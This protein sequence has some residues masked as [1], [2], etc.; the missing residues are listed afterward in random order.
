MPLTNIV[1]LLLHLYHFLMTLIFLADQGGS[2]KISDY[3]NPFTTVY[4]RKQ[5]SSVSTAL[6]L[7]M[8]IGIFEALALC[9]GSRTFLRLIGVS[10]VCF[11]LNA[12]FAN[13]FRVYL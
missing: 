6:L 12:V 11:H 9:F 7:A 5:L 8:G 2:T 10:L 1:L 4:E 3:S 13:R